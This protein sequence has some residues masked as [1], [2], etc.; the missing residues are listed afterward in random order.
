MSFANGGRIVTDGLVLSL[1][2]SDKNSY[3]SGST[4]WNDLSGNGLNGTPTGTFPSYN[5]SNNGN[6][7][8]N[9]N[10]ISVGNSSI[11]NL[12]NLTLSVWFKT[13]KTANQILIGKSYTTSYYLNVAPNATPSNSIFSF[14]TRGSELQSTV[15]TTLGNGNWHNIIATMS[16]TTK[17]LYYDGSQAAT[18]TGNIPAVD[19][20]NLVIGNSGNT[21][22]LFSGSIG[23]TLVYNRALLP[24]EVLQNYNVL[25][26]RFG[27]K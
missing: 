13:T 5:S 22:A 19:S 7:V 23:S 27:L 20:Y 8:F 26:S 15:I 25:K 11:L 24:Q 21:S 14:W 10:P 3:V 9:S 18:G 2:A 6:L 17:T 4:T 16:G 12:T 1:D